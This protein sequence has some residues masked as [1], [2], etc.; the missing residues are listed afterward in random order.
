MNISVDQHSRHKS[1]SSWRLVNSIVYL[2]AITIQYL[3]FLLAKSMALT[4]SLCRIQSSFSPG[5]TGHKAIVRDFTSSILVGSRRFFP[6]NPITFE[7]SL[8][9]REKTCLTSLVAKLFLEPASLSKTL[10]RFGLIF[11]HTQVSC[12]IRAFAPSSWECAVCSTIWLLSSSSSS[13]GAMNACFS[14]KL[15]LLSFPV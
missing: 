5:F 7:T 8:S 10:A 12:I 1:P 3:M 15:V 13:L 9:W 2:H 14:W 4:H 6:F 11:R